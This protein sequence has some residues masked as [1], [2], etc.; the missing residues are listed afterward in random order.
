MK[1]SYLVE[2]AVE[3]LDHALRAETHGA[4]RIELC[5]NLTEGGTTPSYGM[6]RSCY[7]RLRIPIHVMLR[8]R[9]GHFDYSEAEFQHMLYDA[10]LCAQVGVRGVVF[11]FL[12]PDL[13]LDE[14]KT[15]R[16]AEHCHALGLRMTFHRAIDVCQNP[17]EAVG[18]IADW[19]IENVLTSGTKLTAPEGLPTI[20]TFMRHYGDRI[21]I[22][23]GCGINSGNVH[24]FMEAGVPHIHFTSHDY[25]SDQLN[26]DFEFG[27]RAVFDDQYTID[28]LHEVRT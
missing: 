14:D 20:Q 16:M 28:I 10:E 26:R 4:D 9:A 23:A 18:K 8:C 21:N 11:G 15:Q 12:R 2:V 17:M 27:H 1:H 13:S 5:A 7:E 22:L 25:V 24:Q 3:A 6:I 19:G